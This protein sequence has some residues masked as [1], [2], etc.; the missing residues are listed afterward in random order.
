METI[1]ALLANLI[2][3]SNALAGL[4]EDRIFGEGTDGAVEL[5]GTLRR[6]RAMA[7]PAADALA[8]IRHG[9]PQMAAELLYHSV[10]E[11]RKSGGDEAANKIEALYLALDEILKNGE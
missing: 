8:Q 11:V 7:G 10:E 2:T 3:A 4:R 6:L 5:T 9:E 1:I